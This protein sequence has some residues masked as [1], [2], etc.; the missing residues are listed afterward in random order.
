M[1]AM[2]IPCH[3]VIPATV[4]QPVLVVRVL[5]EFQS[6]YLL[7]AVREVGETFVKLGPQTAAFATYGEILALNTTPTH[8]ITQ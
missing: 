1:P 8:H 5:V 3:D 7:Y 2:A 6:W 4:G